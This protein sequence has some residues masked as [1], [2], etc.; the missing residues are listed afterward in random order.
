VLAA[1]RLGLTPTMGESLI[2]PS[3]VAIIVGGI[4]SLPGGVLGGLIIGVAAGV[5]SAF[6]PAAS[7]VVIYVIMTVVLAIR[8]RGLMGEEGL[9]E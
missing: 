3:F 4:G 2:M 5:T 9:Y 1:G 8:P 7:E 6:Y